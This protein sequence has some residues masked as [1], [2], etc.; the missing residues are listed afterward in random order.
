MKSFT[1]LF[2]PNSN[3]TISKASSRWRFSAERA[4]KALPKLIIF[5]AL[6]A[7]NEQEAVNPIPAVSIDIQVD[8]NNLQYDIDIDGARKITTKNYTKTAQ[9]FIGY[10]DNGIIVYRIEDN[11]FRAYDA[12][13]P[14]DLS[15]KKNISVAIKGLAL[16]CPSCK[17]EFYFV[18]D[19]YP[20]DKSAARFPLKRYLVTNTG[21]K[22]IRIFN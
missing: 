17:S 2:R 13:C 11:I 7:C 10:N 20:T 3:K 4:F 6:L 15:K 5:L 9:N 21:Y 1:D 22:Q 18:N 19:C 8:F 16:Q 14:Y 12:T